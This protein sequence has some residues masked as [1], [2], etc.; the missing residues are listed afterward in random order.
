[1]RESQ[2][3]GPEPADDLTIQNPAELWRRIFPAW[4]I[5]DSNLGEF[6]LSTQAFE[7]SKDGTPMSDTIAAESPG[8]DHMLSGFKGYGLASITAV[9]VRMCRQILQRAPTSKDP[10][11]AY[12]VG[13]KT[14]SAKKCLLQGTTM[15][16][17]PQT[18]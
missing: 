16:V 15:V 1:M 8:Q 9:H 3:R 12:V 6:R 7:D 17:V 13:R 11:H 14:R 2:D 18:D 5:L 4:W 10:A